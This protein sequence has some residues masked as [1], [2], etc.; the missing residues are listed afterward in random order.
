MFILLYPIRDVVSLLF[1][2][3]ILADYYPMFYAL[4]CNF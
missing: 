2:L 3:F 1:F 4:C